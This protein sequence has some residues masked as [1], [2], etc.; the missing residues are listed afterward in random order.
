M[1]GTGGKPTSVTDADATQAGES[2]SESTGEDSTAADALDVF[3]F[4]DA[5]GSDNRESSNGTACR[6]E[7]DQP[8]TV[9]QFN[10]LDASTDVFSPARTRSTVAV[11]S[12][13]VAS[14]EPTPQSG[15]CADHLEHW[16]LPPSAWGDAHAV[17]P[18]P[19][20]QR[21]RR[22][23]RQGPGP[24][25]RLVRRHHPPLFAGPSAGRP[26]VH[27]RLLHRHGRPAVRRDRVPA[28][29]RGR[30]R[31]PTPEDVAVSHGYAGRQRRRGHQQGPAPPPQ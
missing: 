19:A 27:R 3:A 21:Q 15:C 4:D 14:F 5:L 12:G 22:Q 16:M 24:D 28:V 1:R 13:N 31:R 25:R 30:H 10:P 17:V 9:C 6:V 8:V 29:E 2:A 18:A 26:D 7:R 20:Q 11:F 23:R